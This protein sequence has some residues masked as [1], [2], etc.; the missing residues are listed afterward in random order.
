MEGVD[1]VG[2]PGDSVPAQVL[3]RRVLRQ[4]LAE[5]APLHLP[6]VRRDVLDELERLG[7]R[8]GGVAV[9]RC[10]LGGRCF[11]HVTAA[12]AS[13]LGANVQ[14]VLP[15]FRSLTERVTPWT[16]VATNQ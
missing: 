11:R 5:H 9:G 15:G 7:V 4:D 1:N 2:G 16:L 13:V 12:A 3:G 14:F 10:C 6:G 8:P